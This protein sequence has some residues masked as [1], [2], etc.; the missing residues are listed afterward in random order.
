VYENCTIT[1]SIL[2]SHKCHAYMMF[3][4]RRAPMSCLHSDHDTCVL[5]PAQQ[6]VVTILGAR[7]CNICPARHEVL[8][9]VRARETPCNSRVHWLHDLKVSREQ[10][11]KVTLVDLAA[12][13]VSKL[14]TG[15]RRLTKGV[16]TGIICL[17]YRVCTTGA[18]KPSTASPSLWKSLLINLWLG[19]FS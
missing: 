5:V 16:E 9:C 4:H 12:M 7:L 8:M 3:Q 18:F 10:D 17:L 11:V 2:P 15:T 13:L 6:R 19:N 14:G 1:S